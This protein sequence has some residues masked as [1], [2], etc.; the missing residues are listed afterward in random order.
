MLISKRFIDI[1]IFRTS[2]IALALSSSIVLLGMEAGT[3]NGGLS[4]LAVLFSA[5]VLGG[6]LCYYLLERNS[7]KFRLPN[8]TIVLFSLYLL[9]S[10]ILSAFLSLGEKNL[11]GVM[12]VFFWN[13]TPFLALMLSYMFAKK[14]ELKFIDYS[15]FVVMA[16][17]LA[18]A[19]YTTFDL[20]NYFQESHLVTSYFTLYVLPLLMLIPSKIVKLASII[21]VS[22]VVFSSMK[23]GGVIAIM[24]SLFVYFIV[25]QIVNGKNFVWGAIVTFVVIAGLGG[26][27]IYLG[28]SGDADIFERIENI[29]DDEGSGRLTVWWETGR[30]IFNQDFDTFFIGNGYNKVVEHS[31]LALSAHND[32]LE[33][34][35][36][37]G[38]FGFFFY[39]SAVIL[40]FYNCYKMIKEKSEIAPHFAMFCVIYFIN[41]AISHIA[42]YYW[43]SLNMLCLGMFFGLKAKNSNE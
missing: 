43:M 14:Y 3:D 40:M 33:A 2:L 37:F 4:V 32:Y 35:F 11:I 20:L 8:K 10:S 13:L 38:V 5:V 24:G 1:W 21:F 19:Y 26:M 41:S 34:F 28:M 30:L 18:Y 36:D 29:G 12:M 16:L 17:M 27:F 39:V 6:S 31:R 25:H 7:L 9:Y 22:I 42:L 23:R 15:I